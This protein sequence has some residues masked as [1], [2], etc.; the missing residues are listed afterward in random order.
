MPLFWADPPFTVTHIQQ[1]VRGDHDGDD[2]GLG[3]AIEL[4][5]TPADAG[6]EHNINKNSAVII[7]MPQ[8]LD[9]VFPR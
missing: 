2:S 9:F 7:F 3:G 8:L 6:I 4:R 5:F 1:G